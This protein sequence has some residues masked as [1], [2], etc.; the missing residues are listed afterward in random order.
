MADFLLE[1]GTEEIPDWMIDDA[2]ADLRN[3]FAGRLRRIWRRTLFGR[4]RHPGDWFCLRQGLLER[5]PDTQI[6][7]R[8]RTSP[9]VL[10]RLKGS[11]EARHNRR[12]VGK[13]A[14]C[15]RASAMPF[16]ST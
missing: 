4:K 3:K 5:A 15:E 6:V 12:P 7:V 2:L 9:P 14:R 13:G 10:R 16:T 8:V 11:Q 1:I